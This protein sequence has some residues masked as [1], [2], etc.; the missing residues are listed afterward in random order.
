[1][2]VNSL[3]LVVSSMYSTMPFAAVVSATTSSLRGQRDLYLN[4]HPGGESLCEGD[5]V[6]DDC[7]PMNPETCDNL[8]PEQFAQPSCQGNCACPRDGTVLLAL[9]STTCVA[10]EACPQFGSQEGEGTPEDIP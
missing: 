8:T 1:M 5:L 3:L 9:G 2:K 6:W 4:P 7:P 10:I